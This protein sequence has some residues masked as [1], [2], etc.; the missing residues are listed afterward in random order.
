[1][2]DDTVTVTADTVAVAYG[3]SV[4]ANDTTPSDEAPVVNVELFG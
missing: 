4:T 2:S 3:N 1:M